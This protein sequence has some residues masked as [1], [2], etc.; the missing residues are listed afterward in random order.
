[1]QLLKVHIQHFFNKD[2]KSANEKK[3]FCRKYRIGI[4]I[5]CTYIISWTKVD[6]I[7]EY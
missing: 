6:F 5:R 2:K 7:D 3:D 1:M 4:M